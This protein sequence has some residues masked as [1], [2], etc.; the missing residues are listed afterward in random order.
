MPM[1]QRK[2]ITNAPYLPWNEALRHLDCSDKELY[3]KCSSGDLPVY[4]SDGQTRYHPA[5]HFYTKKQYIEPDTLYWPLDLSTTEDKLLPIITVSC[6]TQ[7]NIKYNIQK[8]QKSML[9]D[10]SG[11]E[12]VAKIEIELDAPKTIKCKFGNITIN[13]MGEVTFTRNP[14]RLKKIAIGCSNV[15]PS[16]A[17]MSVSYRFFTASTKPHLSHQL[18]DYNI[19]VGTFSIF[20]YSQIYEGQE[21]ALIMMFS[22]P[23]RE[24]IQ[25]PPLG[26]IEHVLKQ[27]GM[28]EN[29]S[30]LKK[31]ESEKR[32][33]IFRLANDFAAKEMCKF[34]I[35]PKYSDMN[36]TAALLPEWDE[37]RRSN[38]SNQL[39]FR[40]IDTAQ[41]CPHERLAIV[42]NN[43]NEPKIPGTA[44]IPG[45]E[46]M[47]KRNKQKIAT[48]IKIIE[49]LSEISVDKSF[50]LKRDLDAY[51]GILERM[52][53]CRVAEYYYRK[54]YKAQKGQLSGMRKRLSNLPKAILKAYKVTLPEPPANFKE[55]SNNP[56]QYFNGLKDALKE[57]LEKVKKYR[58][59]SQKNNLIFFQSVL[60]SHPEI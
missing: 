15:L 11:G 53:S 31:F 41:L 2:K 48:L 27:Q 16:L 28:T 22:T 46:N 47:A 34:E 17:W 10:L 1:G 30:N 23:D 52:P 42:E 35:S 59:T 38:L 44:E 45:I 36:F 54:D 12:T 55:Y 50:R 43:S 29:L 60:A 9:P 19:H 32:K 14:H 51:K 25:V 26:A 33:E 6:G 21:D 4:S 58:A 56:E 8:L 5:S 13:N 40:Q 49:L 3:E 57:I 7:N 37:F 18:P 39:T 24:V 20:F